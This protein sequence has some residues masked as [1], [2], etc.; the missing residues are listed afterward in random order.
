GST[1]PHWRT[2]VEHRWSPPARARL[3]SWRS[4][5]RRTTRSVEPTGR[6]PKPAR[7]TTRTLRRRIP[8]TENETT[9]PC[10]TFPPCL[11]RF[12]RWPLPM[13]N[14]QHS[15]GGGSG[16]ASGRGLPC[17][18]DER[19]VSIDRHLG[20]CELLKDRTARGRDEPTLAALDD[21]PHRSTCQHKTTRVR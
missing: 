7:P 11:V 12:P 8:A 1:R 15:V 21:R 14:H 17:R 2:V 6:A 5:R 13:T 19:T 18:Q 3:S 4:I 16:A 9:E 20:C 10:R